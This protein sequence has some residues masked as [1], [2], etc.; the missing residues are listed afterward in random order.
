MAVVT[1]FASATNILAALRAGE[2]AAVEVVSLY[3]DRRELLKSRVNSIVTPN[4]AAAI[5][6]ARMV[7]EV[8]WRTAG[9]LAGL[10]MTIKD[11]I[12]VA[13][14]PST[15]GIIRPELCVASED[16][17]CVQRL[18]NDGAIVLGKTNV[19]VGNGDWQTNNALFGRTCNPWNPGLTA[20]GSSGGG[21]AAVAAGLT[22]AELGSDIG[23]S[24]RIPA[25]FCGVFGHKPTNTALPRGGHYPGGNLANPAA[26]LGVQGP[27]ARSAVDLETLLDVLCGP[28]GLEAKGWRL[29]LPCA[30]FERLRDC[31]LGVLRLPPWI[32]VEQS[33]LEV[34]Q[35]LVEQLSAMGTPVQEVDITSAFGDY[36]ESYRHYLVLLQCLIGSELSAN[37]RQKAAAK[38]RAYQDSFLDAVADGLVAGAGAMLGMLE[39]AELHKRR[40][41]SVFE[42]IDVLLSPVC[43]SNAFPHDD[44][45]FY[46]RTLSVDGHAIP[47][48]QLSALPSIAS[49]AGLPAT[50]FPTGRYNAAGV[51]IGLQVMGA[52]L[53]DRSTLRFACLIE[54]EI[55]GFTSPPGLD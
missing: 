42:D 29:E 31:R 23:G 24:I 6:N 7:D 12:H 53:E 30:R 2:T 20:G 41:E 22:A 27:L 3:R 25:A 50:A 9:R 28:E 8:G 39:S 55:A 10:P 46:D 44:A 47:Y 54:K 33:I 52:Y 5:E 49:F 17:P 32:R 18:R 16:G 40:W 15:G 13:G 43:N 21:A 14:L 4:Y 51:P 11:G 34:Q 26:S 1:A 36:S 38:L 48:Y 37:A 35:W 19:P 45:F